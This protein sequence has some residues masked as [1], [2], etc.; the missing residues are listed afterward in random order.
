MN[1]KKLLILT[2]IILFCSNYALAYDIETHAYLTKEIIN[3]YNQNFENK[4][5]SYLENYLIDGSRKEDEPPRWMNHFYD[6]VYHRGLSEDAAIDPTYRLGNWQA[7]K[8]W[9][10]DSYNQ[11]NILYKTAATI[12]SILSA[13]EQKKIELITN[14]TDFTWKR[15]LKFYIQG[16]K[17]KAMY[18]LGHILHLIEDTA[19]PDHTRN[20][21]HPGDSPYEKYTAKYNL[22][23]QDSELKQ[24]L[25]NKKP[26]ILNNLNS[27]FDE[28]AYYSNNNFYSK[29]TIGIQSGYSKPEPL[30]F[31]IL[32]DGRNY[33]I[34]SDKEFGDYPIVMAK[35]LLEIKRA[36]LLDRP[37]V[38]SSYWSRLSTK[39]VQYGSGIIDLFFREVEA[40]KNNPEY[41]VKELGFW[42]KFKQGFS[43]T[44]N[45]LK[46]F[47]SQT[48]NTT[49]E[50]LAYVFNPNQNENIYE[51]PLNPTDQIEQNQKS[52]PDNK[53]TKLNP[54]IPNQTNKKTAT[55]S[56][57]NQQDILESE[58]EFVPFNPNTTKTKEENLEQSNNDQ[59]LTNQTNQNE[60]LVEPKLCTFQTNQKPSFSGIIINEIAWMGTPESSNNEWLELKNV[61]NQTINLAGWWLVDQDEQIKINFSKLSNPK[62]KPNQFLLLERTNDQTLPHIS[63]D[64]IY[65][66]S[67]AN[68]NEGLR[69][70]DANCNLIDEVLAH[71]FWPAGD[72]AL[73]RTAERKP[74]LSWQT[75]PNTG[76]T[77]KA[78]NTNISNTSYIGGGGSSQAEPQSQ[79]Q[80][81]QNILISEIQIAP[82]DQ[83]WVELYNPNDFDLDLSG[84]Y[85]QR[86]TKTGSSFSSLVSKTNFDGRI[87]KAKGFFL[88]SRKPHPKS[89]IIIDNLTLTDSNTIQL[90]DKNGNIIDLVGWGEAQNCESSCAPNPLLNQS[91]QRKTEN[92]F[93]I[94]TNNNLNDFEISNCPSPGGWPNKE[95]SFSQASPDAFLKN[96]NTNHLVFSEILFNPQGNDNG[97]EFIELY[98]PTPYEIDV[99]DWSIKITKPNST[100]TQSVLTFHSKDQTKILPYSFLLL[101]FANY[102]HPIKPADTIRSTFLP[103]D[104]ESI[105]LLD[106]NNN[107]VDQIFYQ[108]VPEG[109]SLERKAYRNE[110]VLSKDMGEFWGNGCDTDEEDDFI[111][112]S[113]PNPQN[114]K[115]L[116]EPR[117]PPQINNLSSSFNLQSS[118][119]E[120]VF[121]PS[122]DALANTSTLI[123]KILDLNSSMP[124]VIFAKQG[125]DIDFSSGEFKYSFRIYELNKIYNYEFE[126]QDS[127]GF[128]STSSL[129][130]LAQSFIEQGYFFQDQ[131]TKKYYF[132][133]KFNPRHKFFDLNDTS[134][135]SGMG[136]QGL[137]FFFNQPATSTPILSFQNGMIIENSGQIKV[138]YPSCGSNSNNVLIFPQNKRSCLGYGNHP[139][140]WAY[141]FNSLEDDILTIELGLDQNQNLT[142][143]D[144]LTLAFYGGWWSNLSFE[145]YLGFIAKDSQKYYFSNAPTHLLAPNKPQIESLS[146][147]EGDQKLIV[148]FKPST[149]PDS[150]DR[151]LIYEFNYSTTTEFN[152]S[153]WQKINS[154]NFEFAFGVIYPQNYMIGLRALDE[155]G[156]ISATESAQWSFPENF[157]ILAAQKQ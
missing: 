90:K 61:S 41:L 93:L 30:Y 43:N 1:N 49:A 140:T 23:N 91:L 92:N 62:I 63:A 17:E 67:L 142:S 68:T 101:G 18:T 3:F 118:Q 99:I 126:V 147:D 26:I 149:D 154:S 119:I 42:D 81:T 69:L 82:A 103:N 98:N 143:K 156:N 137:V 136:Y 31:Q 116:P 109:Y 50:F 89:D 72:S 117:N 19:V 29:D 7:S 152:D 100:S 8:Y 74:D 87:I 37:L 60:I 76:G 20:D 145:H 151:N 138:Y 78:E 58:E 148:S 57:K 131:K 80:K 83:R 123:Y 15:A 66:G 46:K 134:T 86:K 27:Y 12:F 32:E 144:Y 56:S 59:N 51:I 14:E 128:G 55:T 113:L 54:P 39:A 97:K 75:S 104:F 107:V 16:E 10:N 105:V 88:I 13:M 129:S 135:D 84:F 4:I 79:A 85:L 22:T 132:T 33:G 94:D 139:G 77:P 112:R 53:L 130:V 25:N 2:L 141:D 44:I 11:N 24:K 6:P 48:L 47:G 52:K 96:T 9:A 122:T 153:N 65:V 146:F 150:L 155:F 36:E 108:D 133:L 120:I 115:S 73:R 102:Y 124:S 64:L 5:P 106:Q 28:L 114:S 35:K 21:P 110:C 125:Q 121:K 111:K 34:Y 45:T 157:V 70:F 71:P 95:C 40:N 38:M 127:D